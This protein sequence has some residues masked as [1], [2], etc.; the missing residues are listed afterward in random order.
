MAALGGSVPRRYARALFDIGLAK[1]SFELYGKELEALADI[2]QRSPELRHALENPIFQLAQRRKLLEAVLPRIGAS[3]ETQRLALL[4]LD[5]QRISILPGIARAYR[6]M[7]DQ[8]LGRVRAT[9]TTA[10]PL[11]PAALVSVQRALERRT[12]KKVIVTTEVD[13]SLIGGLVARVGDLLLD[14]SLRSRL[15]SLRSR[16]LN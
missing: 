11:D 8:Q 5:R 13:P 4:L 15:E 16:V 10:K 9:V 12:G 7:V 3:A 14:G 2:Y 1:G 6:E